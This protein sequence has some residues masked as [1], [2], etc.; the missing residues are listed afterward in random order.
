MDKNSG[1]YFQQL[2]LYII[3]FFI[4]LLSNET[5]IRSATEQLIRDNLT[6]TSVTK[7]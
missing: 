6:P 7:R 2:E 1:V 3:I 5:Y 4:F